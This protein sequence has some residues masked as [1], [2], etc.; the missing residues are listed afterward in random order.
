M[1][2]KMNLYV[3]GRCGGR[4]RCGAKPFEE[5][6]KKKSHYRRVYNMFFDENENIEFLLLPVNVY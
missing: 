2:V 4:R 5:I 3:L 1:C 6:E